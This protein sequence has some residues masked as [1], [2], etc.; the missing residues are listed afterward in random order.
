MI[1][2][3]ENDFY[4]SEIK[5]L[6]K[7]VAIKKVFRRDCDNRE[8]KEW[9]FTDAAVNKFYLRYSKDGDDSKY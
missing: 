8:I 6:P 7:K 3:L 5:N 2:K 9:H 1:F 4:I